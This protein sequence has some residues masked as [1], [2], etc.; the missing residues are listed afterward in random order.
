MCGFEQTALCLVHS[1][2]LV[3]FVTFRYFLSLLLYKLFYYLAFY[4]LLVYLFYFFL[5]VLLQVCVVPLSLSVYL[6]I[7]FH[8]Q[9]NN[10]ELNYFQCIP[11]GIHIT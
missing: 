4:L 6:P 7:L 9:Y 3:I 1:L 11:L 8:I 10:L 5:K 2:P